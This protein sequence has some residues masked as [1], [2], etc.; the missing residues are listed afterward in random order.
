[1]VKIISYPQAK[2]NGNRYICISIF[3]SGQVY[4]PVEGLTDGF[5]IHT[6]S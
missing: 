5:D 3:Y 4:P 6:I 2:V 1:M